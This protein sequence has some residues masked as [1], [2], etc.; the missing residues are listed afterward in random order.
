MKDAVVELLL[1]HEL[2]D[3]DPR[4]R[5]R[6][7]EIFREDP[8]DALERL[9]KAAAYLKLRAVTRSTLERVDLASSCSRTLAVEKPHT[10]KRENARDLAKEEHAS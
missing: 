10:V 6:L 4:V 9:E 3:F 7:E 8:P 5:A 1:R 2:G